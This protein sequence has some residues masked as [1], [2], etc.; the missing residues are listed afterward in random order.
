M[1]EQMAGIIERLELENF[2]CHKHLLIDFSPHV[3]FIVGEN[4]SGKS[5]ILRVDGK[6]SNGHFDL[7]NSFF[8]V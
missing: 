3:N 1:N 5:A 7:P 6:K 4:G 8:I 2:M